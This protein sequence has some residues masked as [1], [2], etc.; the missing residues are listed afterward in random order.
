MRLAPLYDL[1]SALPYAG[2]QLQKLKLAM[3]IGDRYRLRDI[4]A[5]RWEKL[6]S[7]LKLSQDEVR[8]RVQRVDHD[9]SAC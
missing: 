2:N 8:T 1:A 9:G 6:A 5:Y 3:S 7:E 4:G